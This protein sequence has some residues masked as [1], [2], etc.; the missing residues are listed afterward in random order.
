[1]TPQSIEKLKQAKQI[2]PALDALLH[3]FAARE[4]SRSYLN[5][6]ILAKRMKTE[7]FNYSS[8]EYAKSLKTLADLGFG[9]LDIARGGKIRGLKE[10]KVTL[11][12]LGQSALSGQVLPLTSPKR[13]NR[14]LKLVH[15]PEAPRKEEMPKTGMS[16]TFVIGKNP[17]DVHIPRDLPEAD[18]ENIVKAFADA[19]RKSS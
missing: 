5:L 15:K 1:M 6:P 19:M 3:S 11:Q 13:R 10:I 8:E 9:V 14:F 18:F 12:S 16:L 4:R 7:G 17:V 2:D